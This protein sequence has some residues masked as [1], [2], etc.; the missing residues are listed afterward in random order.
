MV[1]TSGPSVSSSFSQQTSIQFWVG[2]EVPK[3][4]RVSGSSGELM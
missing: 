3:P 4:E 1:I 2:A